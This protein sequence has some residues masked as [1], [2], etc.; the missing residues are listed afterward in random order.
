MEVAT[1][2]R[3]YRAGDIP[4]E[5]NPFHIVIRVWNRDC[6]HQ[7]LGVWV[8]RVCEQL[9]SLAQLHNLPQVHH[10]YPVADVLNHGEVMGNKQVRQTKLF[11]QIFK[12]V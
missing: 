2:G 10:R 5:E 7:R 3:V 9:L 11:L 1:G 6:R 12:H 8:L 4:L